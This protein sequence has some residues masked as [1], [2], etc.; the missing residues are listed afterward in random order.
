MSDLLLFDVLLIRGGIRTPDMLFPPSDY[1]ALRKLLEAIDRSVYDRLKKDCL[2]YILLKWSWDTEG[3]DT[4]AGWE[5]RFVEERC[6]PPQFVSL[7]NAYW[8]LD[9]GSN[10]A[11]AVSILCDARLNRDYVSKILQALSLSSYPASS[12]TGP[13]TATAALIV[14]YIRTAKPPL[15]E[16]DDVDL[17]VLS[18]VQT[19][20]MDAWAYQRTFSEESQTRERLLRKIV[21]CCLMPKPKEAPL[22]QLV[23]LPLVPYEE[24]FLHTLASTSTS[25][26]STATPPVVLSPQAISILQDLVCVR[27]IQA[28]D[29]TR[30]IKLDRQFSSAPSSIPTG[31]TT[32]TSTSQPSTGSG[33]RES[34]ERKAMMQ[35]LLASLPPAERTLLEEEIGR[36]ATGVRALVQPLAPRPLP[37]RRVPLGDLS[38]S[39]E[40]VESPRASVSGAGMGEFNGVSTSPALSGVGVGV[41]ASPSLARFD[42]GSS[43]AQARTGRTGRTILGSTPPARAQA[44]GA[45]QLPSPFATLAPR[46]SGF[47]SH[48]SHTAPTVASVGST[49]GIKFTAFGTPLPSAAGMTSSNAISEPGKTIF[50]NTT[51]A[52]ASAS[53]KGTRTSLFE[54][55]GSAKHAPNAFYNPPP[56]PTP[57]SK[58]RV[59]LGAEGLL[60]VTGMGMGVGTGGGKR[61]GKEEEE[62]GDDVSMGSGCDDEGDDHG[63]SDECQEEAGDEGTDG[64]NDDDDPGNFITHDTTA[65]ADLTIS[66]HEDEEDEERGAGAGLG[67]SVFSGRERRSGGSRGNESGS[68]RTSYLSTPSYGRVPSQREADASISISGNSSTTK[69]R[70]P[71]GAFH[72]EADESEDE[73]GDQDRHGSGAKPRTQTHTI[74]TTLPRRHLRTEP[75]TGPQDTPAAY[76]HSQSYS[77]GRQVPFR[78]TKNTAR[79]S[80]RGNKAASKLSGVS[81]NQSIPGSLVDDDDEQENGD[82]YD[83]STRGDAPIET[84]AE[85]D[86]EEEDD[87]AP[88]PARP[89]RRTRSGFATITAPALKPD[90]F[91]KTS[92]KAKAKPREDKTPPRRSSRLSTA[93]SVA[94]L[95]PDRAEMLTSPTKAKGRK[96]TA[97]RTSSSGTGAV[98]TR[99]SARRKL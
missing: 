20:F 76:S 42:V 74:S 13:S 49:S 78:G 15:T 10:L 99:S 11:K 75:Q 86:E 43:S 98:V 36:V 97:Q 91:S 8:L 29:Y 52:G 38:M 7:A 37:G 72:A 30:A 33:S 64:G 80:T 35:D 95:S 12:T 87:I 6:I 21:A 70:A 69:R 47:T 54:T 3:R 1:P 63:G 73:D 22:A 41:S 4:N 81:L 77:Q 28:G 62:V 44:Q 94:S 27:A 68:G 18:L 85:Q 17:Y 88:L 46:P 26:V 25:S 82:E 31:G 45:T 61:T 19:S 67:F 66:L 50:H 51:G 40:D 55:S 2:V 65:A 92:T 71:P 96:S 84:E 59:S 24:S 60:A 53:A 9:T 90:T 39:W 48:L 57:T 14:K 89:S 16:P 56:V 5:T 32:S 93:S 34:T 58:E 23:A 83:Y 79:S